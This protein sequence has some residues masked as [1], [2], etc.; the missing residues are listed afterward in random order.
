MWSFTSNIMNYIFYLLAR[1]A[2]LSRHLSEDIKLIEFATALNLG[3]KRASVL[4][5]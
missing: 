5:M 3:A 1:A 2:V 4:Q